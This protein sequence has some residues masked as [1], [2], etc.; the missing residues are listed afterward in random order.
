MT[1]TSK[2]DN[3]LSLNNINNYNKILHDDLCVVTKKYVILTNEYLKFIL[4]RT[5]LKNTNYFRFI[6]IRG[7]DTITN[8]FNHILYYT[9]NLDLTFYHCQ[10]AYYYYVEFIE[11]TSEEQHTFLQLTSRD[12]TTY[13][14]KK[15]FV[16][17]IE[18]KNKAD[19][20][21][22]SELKDTL[23][24]INEHINIF[25]VIFAFIVQ[26][27]DFV[28]FHISKF[29]KY[30]SIC[31]KIINLDLDSK[32]CKVFYNSI[33]IIMRNLYN[34]LDIDVDIDI[35]LDIDVDNNNSNNIL[36]NYYESICNIIK[37]SKKV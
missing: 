31:E 35:D 17:L 33:E 19:T 30:K 10:K 16:D 20:L 5:K 2:K 9:K 25:S 27:L 29:E 36:N 4:E 6:I 24:I 3:E 1:N 34:N 12:A 21:C 11:Q 14:Y 22:S 28:D 26:N 23:N 15:I 32:K 18:D 13:V 37:I 8:I 7:F